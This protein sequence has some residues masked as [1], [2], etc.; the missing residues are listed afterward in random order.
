MAQIIE[1]L[2]IW[3]SMYFEVIKWHIYEEHVTTNTKTYKAKTCESQKNTK[4]F[5]PYNR[6]NFIVYIKEESNT[7]RNCLGKD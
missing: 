6:N 7:D 2:S 4:L 3:Q 5:M 1:L